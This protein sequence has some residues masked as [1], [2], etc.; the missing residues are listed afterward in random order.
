MTAP[1]WIT[2]A[3]FL[4]TVTERVT[5]STS[6]Q[7]SGAAISYSI[8]TGSLPG[9]LRFSNTG[10][11]VGTPYSI[12][13][14]IRSQF[15]V[16]ASNTAGKTD[17][18]FYIDTEGPTAPTW[19][20]PSGFLQIGIASQYYAINKQFVDYRLTAEFDKLPPGQKLRFYIEDNDGELPP[21]LELSEDGRITGQI[22]DKLKLSY[23]AASFAGYDL[24]PYD[25]YPYDHVTLIGTQLGTTARFI[26]RTY[27]FYASVT[28]GVAINK[29]LFKIKVED[30]G[31]L[32][33]D[34]TYINVD[35]EQYLTDAGYLL[36]PQWL[37]PA[38]LGV[39]RAN[40]KQ[41]IK[42]DVYD[43]NPFYGPTRYDWNT[44]TIN[45]DGSPSIHPPNFE[46]DTISGALYA[47]LPYQPAYSLSYSFTIWV[48]KQDIQT[49]E[50]TVTAR[51]FTL[52][53]RGDVESTIEW[54]SNDNIGSISPGEVSELYVKA[55]HIGSNFDIQYRLTDGRLPTGLVLNPDGTI[56]GQIEY[57]T[58]TYFDRAGYGYN[59]FTLDGGTTTI[60]K[61][62]S[63]T[64]L[65]VDIYGSSAIEKEFVITVNENSIVKYT[66]IYAEPLLPRNQRTEFQRFINNSFTFDRSFIYR[67]DDQNFGLR[68]KIELY[69]EQ[70]IEQIKLVNYRDALSRYFY[71]K[72][73][74]FGEVKFSK[75]ED[76]NGNYVYDL[77]YVQLIDPLGTDDTLNLL[78]SVNFNSQTV[79]PNSVANMRNQ[80]QTIQIEGETIKTDEFL[81][82]RYMRTIQT[83]TGNP[84]GFILAVPL[85]YALPGKGDTIVKRIKLSDFD[86]KNIHFEIDRLVVKNN[87]TESGAKYL[88]FPRKDIIGTNLGE[89]LSYVQGPEGFGLFTEDGYPLYVEL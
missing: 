74:Y 45:Q 10:T 3:G 34:N 71:R 23:K 40:N 25:L 18:T 29:R 33:V 66:K 51:T 41:I 46:L 85:C 20:T 68:Q 88:L 15:V 63:F 36:S 76:A 52:T 16:R 28:D 89:E 78:G 24:E 6:V 9:G 59:S 5:T 54:V 56:G 31:S 19:L 38:N 69:F 12:G 14:T 37:T 26:A 83:D 57:D 87:L 50:E 1:I 35:T 80:L 82:P 30:P 77:V 53:I 39:V 79:Y 70:G 13:Q 60:D 11:I 4:G 62:Y 64:V 75:A 73:F 84:L 48:I 21:G 32:R 17:R 43:F 81:Q 67:L 2:P 47:T 44:P 65:A 86:F 27:Q 61:N 49:L 58:Q 55:Q 72:Q 22:N 7:A 42:L 8:I